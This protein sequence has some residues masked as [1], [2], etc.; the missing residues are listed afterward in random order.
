MVFVHFTTAVNFGSNLCKMCCVS[1]V[2]GV[3]NP[4]LRPKTPRR[5]PQDPPGIPL[6]PSGTS[7]GRARD[8]PG[9]SRDP[10]GRAQDGSEKAPKWPQHCD[11]KRRV[12]HI[13]VPSE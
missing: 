3:L 4:F 9:T 7:P 10:P 1:R 11:N 12:D 5:P 13:L 6:G 2:G 8:L